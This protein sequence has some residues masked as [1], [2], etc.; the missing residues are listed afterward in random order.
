MSEIKTVNI[1]GAAVSALPQS[2]EHQVKKTRRNKKNDEES[3]Q[4]VSNS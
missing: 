4:K 2:Q 1:N 3:L